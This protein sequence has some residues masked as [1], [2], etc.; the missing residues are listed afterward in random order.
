MTWKRQTREEN[1]QHS[2]CLQR[3]QC[4]GGEWGW[5]GGLGGDWRGFLG[6]DFV[7][8]GNLMFEGDVLKIKFS[9]IFPSFPSKIK[10]SPQNTV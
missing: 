2:S 4:L 8:K 6:K 3:K 10:T 1:S 9:I 7:Y 5:V